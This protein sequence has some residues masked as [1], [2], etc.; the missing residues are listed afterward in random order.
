[1]VLS[2]CLFPEVQPFIR[3]IPHVDWISS[4]EVANIQYFIDLLTVNFEEK[5]WEHVQIVLVILGFSDWL[6]GSHL[7]R[8]Y[9]KYKALVNILRARLGACKHFKGKIR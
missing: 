8:V 4:G 9:L 7:D 3:D 2:D 1:M 5:K 6:Q